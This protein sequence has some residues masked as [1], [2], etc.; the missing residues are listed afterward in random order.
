VKQ[1]YMSLLVK[2][3]SSS[4]ISYDVKSRRSPIS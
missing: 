2:V 3:K 4:A 1:L